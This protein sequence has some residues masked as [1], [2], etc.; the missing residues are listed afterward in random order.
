MAAELVEQLRQYGQLLRDESAPDDLERT[1]TAHVFDMPSSKASRT[2]HGVLLM[3]TSISVLAVGLVA[4]LV[5]VNQPPTEPIATTIEAPSEVTP[6]ANDTPELEAQFSTID[7]EIVSSDPR[8]A[9]ATETEAVVAFFDR[10]AIEVDASSVQVVF[11][12]DEGPVVFEADLTDTARPDD[13]L[14]SNRCRVTATS[15]PDDATI[16]NK[17]SSCWNTA[18]RPEPTENERPQLSYGCDPAYGIPG[19]WFGK[20]N[21][22]AEIDLPPDAPGAVFTLENGKRVLV[23]PA[24]DLISYTGPPATSVEVFYAG[25]QTFTD[26]LSNCL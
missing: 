4:V 22:T 13:P 19:G 14:N 16:G 17:E 5:A 10:K 25:G 23:R 20:R 11:E 6:Q 2:R 8:P 21:F 26:D 18:T 1:P 7:Y 24:S 15:P 12:A 3:A 9:T